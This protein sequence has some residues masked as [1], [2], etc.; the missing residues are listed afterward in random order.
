ML[1]VCFAAQKTRL[2]SITAV[3]KMAEN[4]GVLSR[5]GGMNIERDWVLKT[6]TPLSL[7]TPRWALQAEEQYLRSQRLRG[8]AQVPTTK[9]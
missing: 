5:F 7:A 3:L 9:F 8:N 2:I 6:V 4:P 1:I